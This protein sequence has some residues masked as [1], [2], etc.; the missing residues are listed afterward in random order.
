MGNRNR[1]AASAGVCRTGLPAWRRTGR[2]RSV[3]VGRRAAARGVHSADAG[4]KVEHHVAVGRFDDGR[5]I[6]GPESAVSLLVPDHQAA[7][8]LPGPAFV[9]GIEHVADIRLRRMGM[10][11]YGH[12]LPAQDAP[13]ARTV[14]A[15][16]GTA[17]EPGRHQDS[18]R[19]QLDQ[20]R[21]ASAAVRERRGRRLAAPPLRRFE[22]VRIGPRSASCRVLPRSVRH[23]RKH[24]RGHRV[25]VRRVAPN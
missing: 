14:S 20:Q 1:T 8:A 22:P 6:H 18:S 10:T 16:A 15:G 9:I 12:Q 17:D 4:A 21:T 24:G 13:G 2:P 5:F 25:R 11:L 7:G 23:L 3:D 19:T